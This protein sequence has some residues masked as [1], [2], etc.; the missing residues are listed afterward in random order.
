MSEKPKKKAIICER[1][2]ISFDADLYLLALQRMKE[3]G[4]TMFSRYV[5]TLV[6]KD[7]ALLRAEALNAEKA[8]INFAIAAETS[9]SV[10]LP[11]DKTQGKY[12]NAAQTKAAERAGV[13]MIRPSKSFGGSSSTPTTDNSL[14]TGSGK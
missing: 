10:D 14:K 5:Q 6:R 13:K 2:T 9:E 11:Q 3:E 8:V 4:E 12:Q 7:T 1:R